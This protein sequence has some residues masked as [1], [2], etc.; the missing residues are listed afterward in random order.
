MATA[1]YEPLRS[2]AKKTSKEHPSYEEDVVLFYL[3]RR[4]QKEAHR[5]ET[6]PP[7]L[8]QFEEKKLARVSG[9]I[10]RNLA[11]DAGQV[12][13]VFSLNQRK[14][15]ELKLAL[16]R[17]ATHCA[18]RNAEQY[19]DEAL[20]KALPLV[21][22]GTRPSCAGCKLG[23]RR[24]MR[25][26]CI[27]CKLEPGLRGPSNEYV[28]QAS[29][30]AWMLRIIRNLIADDARRRELLLR[31]RWDLVLADEERCASSSFAI[32]ARRDEAYAVVKEMLQ[33]VGTLPA[34]QRSVMALS[35]CRADVDDVVHDQLHRLAP[36]LLGE[37]IRHR[38][39][40]SDRE[41]AGQLGTTPGNIAT[42]RGI[43]RM[44]AATIDPRWGEILDFILPHRS[45]S[46]GAPPL[47]HVPRAIETDR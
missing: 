17:Y 32:D 16:L 34:M 25:P 24:R 38:R 3:A 20:L 15:D 45:F 39:F 33:W 7:D 10:A 5:G 46:V 1:W 23:C 41:I 37:V 28:F 42:T 29:F 27:G 18:V 9:E 19:A 14:Y 40:A 8:S 31:R 26:E 12:E 36:E 47:P 44:K 6:P 35:M 13:E 43:A 11:A 4:C 2:Y 22:A 21:T 30:L